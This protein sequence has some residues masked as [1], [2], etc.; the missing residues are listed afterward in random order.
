MN[1]FI[2]CVLWTSL[3]TNKHCLQW[4]EYLCQF[5]HWYEIN[6]DRCNKLYIQ[7][8]LRCENVSCFLNKVM[9]FR[10]YIVSFFVRPRSSDWKCV[11]GAWIIILYIRCWLSLLS[12]EGHVNGYVNRGLF[13]KSTFILYAVDIQIYLYNSN[14]SLFCTTISGLDVW[15]KVA[16][17]L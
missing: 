3:P 15:L 8:Q 2:L 14:Y 11:N 5:R 1:N 4:P 9:S 7:W 16:Y 17:G 6:H 10:L 13:E 12:S